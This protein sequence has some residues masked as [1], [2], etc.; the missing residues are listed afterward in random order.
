MI[1]LA[2]EIAA[3]ETLAATLNKNGPWI[4]VSEPPMLGAYI[5]AVRP[6]RIQRVLVRLRKCEAALEHLA[7]ESRELWVVTCARATLE[8]EP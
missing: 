6:D 3:L 5:N 7:T 4:T 2:K 8:D 1:T